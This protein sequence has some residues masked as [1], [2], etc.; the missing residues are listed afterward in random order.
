MP[1]GL[2][3]RI[4]HFALHYSEE[5]WGPHDPQE[6]YPLRFNSLE[7]LFLNKIL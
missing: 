6:F 7:A 1:V 5:L 2:I 4:D 3:V